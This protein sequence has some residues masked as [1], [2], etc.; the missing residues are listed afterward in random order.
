MC[1]G[2]IEEVGWK[3][4]WPQ[5]KDDFQPLLDAADV[6]TLVAPHHGRSSGYC[7]EMMGT[8]N[9]HLVLISDKYGK[10]PTDQGFRD[11]PLGLK[12]GGKM[13][14]FLSTKTSGRIQFIIMKL[15]NLS[16]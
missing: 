8:I 11:N 2:D 10:E 12:L 9:P 16:H 13:T 15:L 14:K 3:E 7:K 6:I 4:L 1:P 5:V